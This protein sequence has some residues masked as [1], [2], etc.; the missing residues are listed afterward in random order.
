MLKLALERHDAKQ[1]PTFKDREYQT[2][3]IE[4]HG[5]AQGWSWA[6]EELASRLEAWRGHGYPDEDP[7][8]LIPGAV[9]KLKAYK[10]FEEFS[11]HLTRFFTLY[12]PDLAQRMRQVGTQSETD[13]EEFTRRLL[14]VKQN[15]PGRL[16]DYIDEGTSRSREIVDLVEEL[17]SYIA[18]TYP[19]G[20]S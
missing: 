7:F 8:T 17:R 15:N 1:R 11:S 12:S 19:L 14:D 13:L 4:L 2:A 6:A 10:E 20:P 16:G 9:N 3:L 5:R 18:S